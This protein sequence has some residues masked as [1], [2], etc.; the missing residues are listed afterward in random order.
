MQTRDVGMASAWGKVVYDQQG[1]LG[2]KRQSLKSISRAQPTPRKM[3][4]IHPRTV[5]LLGQGCQLG[6]EGP[7]FAGR[8]TVKSG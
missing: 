3:Q 2:L 7:G 8:K 5:V 1:I 6:L 4:A